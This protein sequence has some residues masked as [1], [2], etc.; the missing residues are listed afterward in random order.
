[1]SRTVQRLSISIIVALF[2]FS[3]NSDVFSKGGGGF[4]RSFGR[5]YSS[6]SSSKSYGRASSSNR[7][8][9]KSYRSASR[10]TSSASRRAAAPSGQRSTSKSYG[11]S[12]T[13]RT[14]SATTRQSSAVRQKQSAMSG[15][16]TSSAVSTKNMTSGQRRT[17]QSQRRTGT[18]NLK[19]ENRSLKRQTRQARRETARERRRSSQAASPITVNNFGGYYP[20]GG[21]ST[22]GLG[23]SIMYGNLL[24]G[25]YFHDRYNHMMHRSW[26]WH[27]HHHDYDRSHW[28]K[29]KQSEY[30]RWRAY[31]DSQGVEKSSNYV[32]PGTNR[33]EDYIESHVEEN[34]DKFYGPNAAEAVT[35][36]ELPNESELRET[37]LA[38]G[39]NPAAAVQSQPER[40]TVERK[41]VVQKKTSGG[42]WFLI[43]FGSLI[44]VGIVVLVLYNKGYF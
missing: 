8:S 2:V 30:E 44:I 28:S 24:G 12:A 32:D 27:Y 13:Q 31:Y 7:S 22:F 41:V 34:S 26:L 5:S 18:R 40:V 25:L 29:D 15:A 20:L 42:A 19:T 6:R 33:D 35:V 39:S 16:R 38:S 4:G 1:M 9:S 23:A 11:Q 17:L 10:S 37:V 14:G 21:Y 3:L 43:V 36:E